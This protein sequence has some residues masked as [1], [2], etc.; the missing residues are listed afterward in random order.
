MNI[1]LLRFL[2][3]LEILFFLNPLLSSGQDLKQFTLIIPEASNIGFQNKLTETEQINILTYEYYYNGGG[4]AIGDINNDGLPDIYFSGNSVANKLYLNKGDFHFQDISRFANVEGRPGWKTGVT[5]A[6]VNNDGWL[7]IYLCHSGKLQ[8]DQLKNELFINNHDL[9]FTESAAEYGLDDVSYSTQAAFFDYDHDGDLDMYLLNH[10]ITTFK[11]FDLREIRQR[12]DSLAGDKLFRNDNGHFTDVSAFSG[13]KGSAIGFGL[14]IGISDL[15]NDGWDDIYIGNDYTEPDYLYIN[16]HNGTFTDTLTTMIN[17]TSQFSMGCDIADINNDGYNDIITLDMM[18]EE[19]IR[20]K[21]LRGPNNYDKYWLQV[22]FGYHHQ[23][24][25]NNLQLNNGNGS[26]SE[27]GQLAGISNTDWSWTPLF[28]DYD[29]DGWKDLLI[30]NG[31]RRNYINMDFLK[32]TFEDAKVKAK[33]AGAK[34]NL[35]ELVNQIP[36]I[37]I[38]NYIYSNNHDLTFIDQTKNWG[39]NINSLS[40]G[41][42][43]ADL[44]GDGDLDLVVN[45]INSSA[46]IYKNNNLSKGNFITIQFSGSE[47]NKFG[48]GNKVEITTKDGVQTQELNLTHG[49]QSSTEPILH[50]GVR[51]SK[52]I[53]LIKVTWMDQKIEIRKNVKANQK[54][55][56]DYKSAILQRNV[57]DKRIVPLF[58][59]TNKI[60]TYHHHE[61]DFVDF[62]TEPLLPHKL[63]TLGPK[64]S[65]SDVNGDGLVDLFLGNGAGTPAELHLQKTD[66][67]FYHSPQNE[68]AA[69]SMQEEGESVFLDIDNDGDNDLFV[70]S[71]GY[72]FE[73]AS[74]L[75][76][77]RLYLN[78]GK[79]NFTKSIN[80]IP[81][82]TIAGLCVEKID[83]DNDGYT[84]L[85]IGGC[86]QHAHYGLPVASKIYRNIKGQFEDVTNKIAPQFANLGMVMEAVA[87]DINND[88]KKD[89]IITGDWMKIRIFIND[90]VNFTELENAIPYSQGWWNCLNSADLDG[91]GDI[92][93]IAGNRGS[94]EQ[95]K[96]DENHPAYLYVKD[97]DNNGSTDPIITYFIKDGTYPMASR[98]ELLDQMVSMRKKYI[99]YH[100][101]SN[102]TIDSMFSPTQLKGALIDTV[103]EMRTCWFENSG[104]GHFK[105]HPFP[106]EVQFSPINS[107]VADDIDNDGKID[108]IMAGNNY[109]V[110][111]EM[112]REDAGYGCYLKNIGNG[113]FKVLP[114]QESGLM[115]KGDCRDLKLVTLATKVKILIAGINNENLQIY[116]IKKNK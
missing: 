48:I 16:N 47:K 90:G 70:V 54:I 13:I 43:Y 63:S 5:M 34:L 27:I 98:D 19:N 114:V 37:D 83:Y 71:G 20:Q 92:D 6:D 76:Q 30:T 72:E 59:A 101:Y 44:D 94:N 52:I 7:D 102:Q 8:I 26:F 38:P 50:F 96:A 65:F 105:K 103:V 25:R 2:S 69:D 58:T 62:K 97:F 113:N 39:M 116:T 108:L 15:N 91:D 80:T 56:F 31:Y 110:R 93:L 79:G 77:D 89:L 67:T 32:Y 68:I 85:F 78:D 18:P 111:A 84:D 41:A 81:S 66:G 23:V 109:S 95:L 73:G 57:E 12:R 87:T 11:N 36:G 99:Y 9:T 40:N 3:L 106:N 104:N 53:D 60:L 42:A 24:M 4:V 49:Y 33:E 22:K 51:A 107:I 88:G 21:E 75:L 28:A 35:L 100:Q 74:P 61:N 29:N 55:N 112:G 115:I 82:D 17:H 14:G 64:F 10:N 46:F 1:Q 45:N 86:V